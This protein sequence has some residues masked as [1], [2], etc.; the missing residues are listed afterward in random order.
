MFYFFTYGNEII[1]NCYKLADVQTMV[2]GLQ[3]EYIWQHTTSKDWVDSVGPYLTN[4]SNMQ[5]KLYCIHMQAAQS[6]HS[7]MA[8]F[9]TFEWIVGIHLV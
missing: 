5:L 9:L 3:G 2:E 6:S 8:L 7:Q 1:A 4:Y